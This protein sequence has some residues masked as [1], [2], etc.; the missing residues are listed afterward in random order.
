[1]TKG[2]LEILVEKQEKEIEKLQELKQYKKRN[3][4]LVR[5]AFDYRK[6]N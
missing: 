1:M 4:E 6:K 5:E 2:E 3:E